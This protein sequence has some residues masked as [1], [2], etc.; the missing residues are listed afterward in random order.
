MPTIQSRSEVACSRRGAEASAVSGV[1]VA[2]HYAPDSTQA[3][4]RVQKSKRLWKARRP[5]R[6]V[7]SR[8]RLDRDVHRVLIQPMRDQRG[9]ESFHVVASL[10]CVGSGIACRRAELVGTDA[11]RDALW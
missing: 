5:G 11:E 4:S 3:L 6:F 8:T 1:M 2:R 7:V 9:R 10:P